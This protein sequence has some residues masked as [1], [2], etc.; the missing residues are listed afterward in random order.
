MECSLS[1]FTFEGSISEAIIEAKKQKKL[2][3]VYLSGEDAESAR[4][5][6]STWT[7][8]KVVA[9]SL[10]KYCILLQLWE[11]STDAA[12]FSA[13]YP[14]KSVPCITIVGYNGLQLWQTE[15]FVSAEI[16][17]SS[18]E[19]AWLSLHIQ[20]TTATVLTA[21]LASKEAVPSASGVHNIASFEQGSSSSKGSTS[22]STDTDV[23]PSD[24]RPLV[25]TKTIEKNKNCESIVECE[26]SSSRSVCAN[27]LEND[28][29]EQ[30]ISSTQTA[31]EL[32]NPV[33]VTPE[34]P[35]IGHLSSS[36]ED[37][38][39]APEDSIN[40]SDHLS[41]VSTGTSLLIVDQGN[42][43][44]HDKQIEPEEDKKADALDIYT[45]A[46]K[47]Y[48]VHLNI[49]LPD[50]VSLQE[51]FSVTSTLSMVKDYVD[52]HQS[53][54]IGP[55]NLAI[56]YP[57]KV[58]SHQD[59]SKSFSDLGLLN[60]QALIVIPQQ[61][62]MGQHKSL[63]HDEVTSMTDANSL[64]G[65]NEGYFVYVKKIL[66]FLN[67]YSYLGGS[68][69]STSS[70]QDSPN[71]TWQYGPNPTL[72]NNIA[73]SRRPYVPY[74]PNRGSSG[75][76]RNDRKSRQPMSSRFGSNIHTLKHDEDDDQFGDRNAFWNGN[77]TQYGG[78]DDGK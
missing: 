54:A 57:W 27:E 19:R 12:Q 46:G 24:A 72:Q 4:L 38:T 6:K 2:F 56:P 63:S 43:V 20:E 52:R 67:P 77:S 17:A 35:R 18:L 39:S 70:G 59:L 23:Q 26:N 45:S 69:S 44:V 13:I 49:R 50:G 11:G 53:S 75:N 15:G 33:T 8:S 22:S 10:A 25:T 78:N 36:I 64:N 16:L 74:S 29:G 37:T 48:D 47:L 7:E 28:E 42:K 51:K 66:S 3:V 34:S 41:Q 71:S 9:E 14:Q 76:S 30:F 65:S 31:K 58:F 60:R 40:V 21:A 55:Y 61:Q 1:S 5:E 32:L 73:G 68:T 62:A